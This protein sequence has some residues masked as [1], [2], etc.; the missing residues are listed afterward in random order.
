ML[1]AANNTVLNYRMFGRPIGGEN[2]VIVFLHG[3][4]RTLDDFND[5]KN[6]LTQALPQ[7]PTPKSLVSGQAVFLALD[8]PGFGGSP[9]A[10]ADG[11]SLDDYCITLRAFFEKLELG[12]V[13][14][15][16]HSLGGR[17]AIKFAARHPERVEK[18][19]LISA[20][21]I[22]Y[23]S[24]RTFLLG[25]GRRLFQTVFYAFGDL[26][27]IVRFRNL[28]G[29]IFGSKD[30]QISHGALRDTL[31]KVLAEDLRPDAAKI[32]VP[33]LLLWGARDQITPLRDGQE[34]H[35]LIRGSRLEVLDSGHFVF[36]EHPEECARR[37]A[38]FLQNR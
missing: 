34:Y 17:I 3:W 24:L 14:L 10:K 31:K 1:M 29:A 22:P 13:V 38:S 18:L 21:G 16:G 26:K 12:H 25:L 27:S 5:L 9:L 23:R 19:V 11:F 33:T 8:L 30:Y 2:G 20:A 7:A 4:G 32:K 37:I 35:T 28:F 15:I 6:H 36:L